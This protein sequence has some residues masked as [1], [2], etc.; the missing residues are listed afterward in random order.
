MIKIQVSTKFIALSTNRLSLRIHT[1]YFRFSMILLKILFPE[2]FCQTLFGLPRAQRA[3]PPEAY[4]REAAASLRPAG[5][6]PQP[7]G[8]Y[9]RDKK[10]L[11]HQKIPIT[12]KLIVF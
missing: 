7:R 8:V 9:N 12:A 6:R 3:A 1:L 2:I 11:D 5:G 4:C 10:F